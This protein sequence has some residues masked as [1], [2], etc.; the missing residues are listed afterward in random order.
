MYPGAEERESHLFYGVES[1][2]DATEPK[3]SKVDPDPSIKEATDR[4][5]TVTRRWVNKLLALAGIGLLADGITGGK[6]SGA[7]FP[8]AEAAE[9]D[10]TEEESSAAAE[11]LDAELPKIIAKV[12]AEHPNLPPK[13]RAA[14]LIDYLGT[15]LFAWG[16]A[17]LMPGGK[18]YIQAVQYGALIALTTAKYSL[19]NPEERHHLKDE[20][21]SNAKAFGVISGTIAVAEGI[22]ADIEKAFEDSYDKLPNKHDQAALISLMA[23]ALSP[24]ATTVGSAGVI[25]KMSNRLA[26]GNQKMIATLTSHVSNLSGFLLFGDPPFIAICEKYGFAEGIKWQMKTMWPMA[27]YSLISS[28]EKLNL[29]IL[30]QEGVPLKEAKVRAK[31]EAMKGIA[32]NLTVL[33]KILAQSVANVAKYFTDKPQNT[34]GLEIQ[35]GE[36]LNEKLVNLATLPF[37]PK[38]DAPHEAHEPGIEAIAETIGPERTTKDPP[39]HEETPFTLIQDAMSAEDAT[40]SKVSSNLTA[41][42]IYKNTTDLNRIKAAVGHN[43]GDVVNVFPFQAGCV[44]FLTPVFEDIVKSLDGMEETLREMTIFCML[45]IFSMFA[46]NYVACK[47]GL[48]LMPDKPHIPLIA[49]IQGGS[50]TAIGNMA[51]VTQFS[52]DDYSL[53]DSIKNIWGHVDTALVGMAYSKA[54]TILSNS[55]IVNIPKP[56]A[57]KKKDHHEEEVNASRRAF[58]FGK[59]KQAA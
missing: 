6:I 39:P 7:I 42:K 17:S 16:V 36:V 11:K 20:T 24:L 13:E 14:K 9:G 22:N 48:T 55:G 37:S 59:G 26:D 10:K 54:L 46:D 1:A 35:I 34:Q 19:S 51:N 4:G 27:L 43:L 8:E 29:E 40:P 58:M 45:M 56:L 25:K 23:S 52:L 41:K 50:M 12:D 44:P 2:M 5:T 53:A 31:K 57:Q 21:I 30:Q 38:F 33:T 47:I 28:T 49:S 32:K 3:I 18:G 15:A